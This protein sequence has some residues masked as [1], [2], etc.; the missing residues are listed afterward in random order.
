MA[1]P[2]TDGK[3]A[4]RRFD[5][6]DRDLLRQCVH[7][8]LCLPTCP[9]YRA[10]GIEQDSPRGR[11]YQM[12]AMADGE[13]SPNDPRLQLHI[14]QCLDCRACETACPSGVHY[15]RLLEATR[16]E[17]KPRSA[18]ERWLRRLVLDGLFTS[19]KLLD[20]AGLATRLYQHS[21]LQHLARKA[22]FLRPL[23]KLADLEGLLP[24]FRAGVAKAGLPEVTPAV[25]ER[26]YRV[27]M[28][29]GC[30][31]AQFFGET[32]QATARVLAANGCEVVVPRAQGC[33]GALHLH[34]GERETAKKLARRNV[35]AFEA[36]GADAYVVNAAGCGST[37]KEYGELLADDPAWAERA[38][39]FSAKMRD[40]NELLAE[41]PLTMPLG[42]IRRRATYHDACHLA[43]GQRIREQPREL[44]RRIPGL[45]L[46][47]LP[48][49]D[50]CCGSAGIYNVTH[51]ELS[52]QMLEWKMDAVESTGAEIVVA[53]NPGCIIQIVHGLRERGRSVEVL[54]PIDLLDRSYQAALSGG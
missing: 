24:R 36:A 23:P 12:L 39:A 31:A 45:E 1:T 10:L 44:L 40:V 27:A 26:K 8:G 3:P 9:T 51:Y 30:V 18:R 21:G 11:I 5:F 54:H 48:E 6:V 7:C 29:E 2:V 33:C 25:G 16:A 28:L 17:L 15:G 38:R 42:E 41:I 52:M 50:T 35:A 47:D 49:S 34:S 22:G 20:A 14:S 37:L 13:I 19:P 4:R 32:N 53:A 43:H 46:V